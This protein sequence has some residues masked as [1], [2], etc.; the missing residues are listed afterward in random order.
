MAK[1]LSNTRAMM[2]SKNRNDHSD[3]FDDEEAEDKIYEEE[4]EEEKTLSKSRWAKLRNFVTKKADTSKKSKISSQALLQVIKE[5][6]HQRHCSLE[7]VKNSNEIEDTEECISVV[8]LWNILEGMGTFLSGSEVDEFMTEELEDIQRKRDE[9]IYGKS[10]SSSKERKQS[11]FSFL[12][13]RTKKISTVAPETEHTAK[14]RR[15]SSIFRDLFTQVRRKT[16]LGVTASKQRQVRRGSTKKRPSFI[17]HD[18]QNNDKSGAALSVT[19]NESHEG[20]YHDVKADAFLTRS[21]VRIILNHFMNKVDE[22]KK[23]QVHDDIEYYQGTEIAAKRDK[24]TVPCDENW[25]VNWDL[26][27]MS[28]IIY[29]AIMQPFRFGFEY[30]SEPG[31]FMYYFETALDFVFMSDLILNFRTGYIN[32]RGKMELRGSKIALRYL[33]S[34]F[35]IDL[36]SSVPWDVAVRLFFGGNSSLAENT[37]AL[38]AIR[39]IKLSKLGRLARI[40]KIIEQLED[41]VEVDPE[42]KSV[43]MATV[44]MVFIAHLLACV[45]GAVSRFNDYGIYHDS[46]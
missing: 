9:E 28:L 34:N 25:R 38:K 16:H 12:A 42:F 2:N 21:E 15:R 6:I 24:F 40:K 5:T 22:S 14:K 46:W 3:L 43:V 36:I 20:Y 45:W 27:T 41:M 29:V 33:K 31:T 13:F 26:F 17:V 19:K 8:D 44:A 11:A 37:R 1:F 23:H 39:L 35:I 18:H 7:N 32:S 4:E 30:E 10:E